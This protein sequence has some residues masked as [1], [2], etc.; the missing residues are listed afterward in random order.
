[1]WVMATALIL[2]VCSGS[3]N[4]WPTVLNGLKL[5]DHRGLKLTPGQLAGRPVLLHFMFTGCSRLC[6]L[7][8]QALRQ[9]HS[10]L[11]APVRERVVLLGVTVDPLNDSPEALASF[12][13]RHDTERPGWRFVSGEPPQVYRL[14]DR[15]QVFDTPASQSPLEA[16]RTALFLYAPD[17]KLVQRFRGEPVDQGRLV[18]ELTRLTLPSR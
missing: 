5:Q 8:V 4:A 3:A 17:G 9:L 2:A 15:L 18:A 12:A 13:R 6:P 1:M 14:L 10:N 16:H 7:Q 11:S